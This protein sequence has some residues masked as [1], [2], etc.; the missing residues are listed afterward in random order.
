MAM[1]KILVLDPLTLMGKELLGCSKRLDNLVGE[2]DFRHTSDDPEHQ[3]SE[4]AGRP[5]LVPP[6]EAPEDLEGF[7]AIVVTSDR[8]TARHD[9]LLAHLDANPD[10]ALVDAT[11]IDCLRERTTPS[12]GSSAP[13]SSRQVRV[14]HPAMIATSALVEVLAHFGRFGGFLVAEDP[15]SIGGQEAVETMAQQA[16]QRIRGAPVEGLIDNQV[17]AFTMLV[18]EGDDLQEEATLLIPEVPLAVTRLLASH[19]HGHLAHLGLSFSEPLDEGLVREA[20]SQASIIEETPLPLRLDSVLDND[21][22]LMT[23]PRFSP[24][25]RHLALTAIADGL[26]IGGALTAIDILESLI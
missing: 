23:P 16:R 15:A 3:L 24:D 10:T 20:L 8:C 17:L 9:H 26:R 18:A 7:E 13:P 19:F 22:V 14:A 12:A 6:L 1:S 25:R 11:R 2:V 4:M 5:G 21:R